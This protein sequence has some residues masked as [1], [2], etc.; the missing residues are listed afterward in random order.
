[1]IAILAANT[2]HVL[3]AAATLIRLLALRVVS[4]APIRKTLTVRRVGDDVEMPTSV[5]TLSAGSYGL[6]FGDRFQHQALI[7]PVAASDERRALAEC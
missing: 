1:M 2:A 5:L 6:W 4:V 7:G 3:A